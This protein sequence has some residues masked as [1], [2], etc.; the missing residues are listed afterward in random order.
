[1]TEPKQ[2]AEPKQATKP[3]PAAEERAVTTTLEE[4][5]EAGLLGEEVDPTPNKAYTVAGVTTGR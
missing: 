2:P 3:K 4:A 5:Q 1:M